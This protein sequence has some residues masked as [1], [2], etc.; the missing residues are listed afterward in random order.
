MTRAGSRKALAKLVDQ[1]VALQSHAVDHDGVTLI[2]HAGERLLASS[3]LV[4]QHPELFKPAE[5]E[6]V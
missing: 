4:E 5:A 1:V 6:A 3:P 2:V